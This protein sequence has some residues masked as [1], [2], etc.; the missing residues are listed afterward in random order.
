MFEIQADPF[1]RTNSKCSFFGLAASRIL[2]SASSIFFVS[3]V[4]FDV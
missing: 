1:A 2:A 4:I 3:P